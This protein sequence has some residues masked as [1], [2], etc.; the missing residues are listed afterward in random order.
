MILPCLIKEMQLNFDQ[1]IDSEC[2][3]KVEALLTF[4]VDAI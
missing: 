3:N 1:K 4:D 2:F